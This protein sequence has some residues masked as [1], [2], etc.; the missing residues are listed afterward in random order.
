MN[1]KVIVF[2]MDGV[3]FDTIALVNQFFLTSFPTMKQEDMNNILTGNFHEE[4]AKFKANNKKL[5][6]TPEEKKA[7]NDKYV[8]EKEMSPLYEGVKEILEELKSQGFTL[9]I[10][11]SAFEKNC[12]PLLKRT[13][14][15]NL[16]DFVATKE[17]SI[18]KV[19]KFKIIAEKYNIK[20]SDLL[21]ITDTLG[22][23][24]EAKELDVPTIA[25]TYGAHGAGYFNK[26]D[27]GNL[28]A[29]VG[30]VPELGL[31]IKSILAI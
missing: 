29:I 4:L 31:A 14:I 19:E 2:D 7:R 28:R 9:T 1:K 21:F 12:L 6:E 13:N 16:F 26:E 27:N 5:E 23:V 8:A 3:L 25:V 15:D 10:N 24:R 11:T 30:S 17:I 20:P 18:S 22:D